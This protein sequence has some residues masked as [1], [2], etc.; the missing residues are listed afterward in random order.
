LATVYQRNGVYYVKFINE[1]G[2]LRANALG[3]P[4]SESKQEFAHWFKAKLSQIVDGEDF[5]SFNKI[6]KRAVGA[7]KRKEY[8]I[9][10]DSPITSQ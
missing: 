7:S 4:G 2:K 6:I 5:T 3:C 1:H 8:A 9:T 10:I